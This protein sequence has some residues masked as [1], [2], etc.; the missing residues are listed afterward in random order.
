[1]ADPIKKWLGEKK[2][3]KVNTWL[4]KKKSYEKPE[5]KRPESFWE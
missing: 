3:W 2:T 5:E 4:G 1:L